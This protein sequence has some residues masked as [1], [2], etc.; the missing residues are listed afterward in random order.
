[1]S[2]RR[3]S[4]KPTSLRLTS[5][6]SEQLAEGPQPLE[7]GGAV[8][9]VAGRRA[10][11]LDEARTL[12][13]AEHAGRPTGGLG[14]LVD[15]QGVLHC[16]NLTTGVSRFAGRPRLLRAGGVEDALALLVG[17]LVEPDDGLRRASALLTRVDDV[18]APSSGRS[19]PTARRR[20]SSRAGAAEPS[21]SASVVSA[22][23]SARAAR[24]GG[25]RSPR[26]WARCACGGV[27][28]CGRTSLARRSPWRTVRR[29]RVAADAASGR[30]RRRRRRRRARRRC[31]RRRRRRRPRRS[32]RAQ[33]A[34]AERVASTPGACARRARRAPAACRRRSGSPAAGSAAGRRRL[35]ELVDDQAGD[36]RRQ[37]HGVGRHVHAEAERAEEVHA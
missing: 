11:W 15:G 1:M 33:G 29:A 10:L 17:L 2:R 8:E 24:R 19:R 12:D 37:L 32:A 35:R 31:R 4:A 18:G 21:V 6:S 14:S 13:V 36:D 27:V 30:A 28:R 25:G 5:C 16:P 22:W 7:L 3:R 9:P 26:A 20:G 23:S 34:C